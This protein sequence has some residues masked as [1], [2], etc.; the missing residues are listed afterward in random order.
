MSCD[1]LTIL[2][3]LISG[4]THFNQASNQSSELLCAVWSIEASTIWTVHG[5]SECTNKRVYGRTSEMHLFIIIRSEHETAFWEVLHALA[6][7]V[8]QA[9][10]TQARRALTADLM[11][12]V[13]RAFYLLG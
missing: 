12:R 4:H 6:E 5:L 7:Q 1:S 3:T 8:K 11:N 10:S 9:L 13:V 2:Y